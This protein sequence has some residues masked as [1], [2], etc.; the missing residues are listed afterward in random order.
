MGS[1]IGGYPRVMLQCSSVCRTLWALLQKLV[2]QD[3]VESDED[4]L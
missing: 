3:I 1:G 2:S 4:V